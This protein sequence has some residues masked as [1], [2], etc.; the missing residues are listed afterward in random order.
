LLGDAQSNLN[1]R[2]PALDGVTLPRVIH[3]D[4]PHHPRGNGEELHAIFPLHV[5]LCVET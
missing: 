4:A 1:R 3:E 5:A 2:G